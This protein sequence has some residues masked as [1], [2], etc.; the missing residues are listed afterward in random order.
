MKIKLII[1]QKNG[2]LWLRLIC[3]CCML[4]INQSTQLE[5]ITASAYSIYLIKEGLTSPLFIEG[6]FSSP[7]PI[8]GGAFDQL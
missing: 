2:F 7:P 5:H 8:P 4:M 6:L 1:W 3:P